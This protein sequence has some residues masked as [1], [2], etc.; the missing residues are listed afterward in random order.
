[1]NLLL[2]TGS[3]QTATASKSLFWEHASLQ[4]SLES[5]ILRSTCVY[6]VSLNSPKIKSIAMKNYIF[7]DLIS[8][9]RYYTSVTI[10]EKEKL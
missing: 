8:L 2:G 9:T 1:M 5:I 6:K 7:V 4:A 3:N 10:T